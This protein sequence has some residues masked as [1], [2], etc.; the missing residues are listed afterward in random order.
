MPILVAQRNA[1]LCER[2]LG[3]ARALVCVRRA[4][5]CSAARNFHR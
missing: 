4:I 5:S 1:Y 3:L 2:I